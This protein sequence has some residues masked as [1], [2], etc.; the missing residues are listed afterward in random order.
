[1]LLGLD[2]VEGLVTISHGL[3]R[4]HNHINVMMTRFVTACEYEN[5]DG[6]RKSSVALRLVQLSCDHMTAGQV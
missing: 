1:M 5:A 6:F 4:C 2:K 3:S